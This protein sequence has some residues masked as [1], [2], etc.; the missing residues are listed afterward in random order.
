VSQDISASLK[1]GT[2]GI[3]YPLPSPSDI[4]NFPKQNQKFEQSS[5]DD[6]TTIGNFSW[7]KKHK[8]PVAGDFSK[9]ICTQ[10]A[11]EKEMRKEKLKGN[12]RKEKRQHIRKRKGNKIVVGHGAQH[13]GSKVRIKVLDTEWN[14]FTTKGRHGESK[15]LIMMNKIIKFYFP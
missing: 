13:W 4:Y 2:R 14:L 1:E 8:H 9:K 5:M 7:I 12:L 11:K 6:K 10:S 15:L 3:F